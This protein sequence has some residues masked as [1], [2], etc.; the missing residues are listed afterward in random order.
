MRWLALCVALVGCSLVAPSYRDNT[1]PISSQANFDPERYQGLW[2]E[3]ARFPVS[4]Q[5]GCTGVTATYAL[6]PDGTISVENT[7]RDGSLDGR[8]RRIA[9]SARI[10]GPGRL[11]VRFDDVPFVNAPYWVLWVDEGYRT[12]VVGVPSGRAGWILNR[13]PQIPQDRFRAALQ[14]L[15]FNGYDVARIVKTPQPAR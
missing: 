15:D 10:T 14:V 11:S 1:A 4:F 7:C 9:G 12:A 3:I 2:Y 5:E 6:R 13:D 8:E